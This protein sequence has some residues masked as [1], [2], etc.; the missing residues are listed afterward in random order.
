MST[1]YW[2]IG[3]PYPLIPLLLDFHQCFGVK[4]DP[5]KGGHVVRR[6]PRILSI[7]REKISHL[8][9]ISHFLFFFSNVRERKGEEKEKSQE[10][11]QRFLGVSLVGIRRAK[12]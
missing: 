7:K 10:F 9:K 4:T 12:N 3:F 2:L 11:L 5:S 1:Y 8:G 6:G